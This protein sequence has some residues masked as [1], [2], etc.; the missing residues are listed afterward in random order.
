MMLTATP[1]PADDTGL[2]DALILAGLPTDDLTEPGRTFFR[3]DR[4]GDAIGFGGFELYGPDALLRSVVVAPE[5]RGMGLGADVSERLI[6]LARDGGAQRVYLLTTSAAGFFT[7]LGF[8]EL[9]RSDAP[10][11]ILSTRQATTICST[12]TML[13]RSTTE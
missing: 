9:D 12:A 6:A 1:V 4:Y 3:F 13:A 2:R 5:Q 11:S 10:A 8:T 7:R